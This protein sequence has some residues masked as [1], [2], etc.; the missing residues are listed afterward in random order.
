MSI[1]PRHYMN[2]VVSIGTRNGDQVKWFG[3]G[4]F[5]HKRVSETQVA[6]FLVT[7]RHVF[8]NR[9]N[10]I[11][12]LIEHNSHNL[13]TV[14]VP[15]MKDGKPLYVVS[16]DEEIDIAV[17]R[18]NGKYF[19]DNGFDFLSF[20]I[21][22][23]AMSSQELLSNGVDE[24]S[25]VYMLGFPM[26]LVNI[27]SN[28]PICRMGCIAR[29]SESQIS[30]TKNIL[31]DIQNFPGNSGSPIVTRAEVLS[32]E[33]SKSLNR[34]VLLGIVHSYIPYQETLINSQTQ[35]VVE[36]RSENSGIA[37]AHPVEFIR[38]LVDKL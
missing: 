37:K 35:Q 38:D 30:E 27:N 25:I 10:V 7:N 3:T 31:V 18:L 8:K 19:E 11:I 15:L 33:G 4:F 28:T 20:D 14:D 26:G 2:A 22:G 32:I 34:S 12:R 21:E 5:I 1:L 16:E 13:K 6:P 23:N 9:Q 24:G 29:M 17:L 36:I